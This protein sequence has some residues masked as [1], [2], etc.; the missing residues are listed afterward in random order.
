MYYYYPQYQQIPYYDYR[1]YT[2]QPYFRQDF[3]QYVGKTVRATVERMFEQPV[4][5]FIHRAYN[6]Q[7]GRERVVIVYSEKTRSGNC[8]VRYSSVLGDRITIIGYSREEEEE[9]Y[10]STF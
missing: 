4:T 10:S 6:D 2:P 7:Q 8:R 3:Q 1:Y 9:D 5:L